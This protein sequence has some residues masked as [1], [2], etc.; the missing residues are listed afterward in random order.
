[1]FSTAK[2]HYFLHSLP[3]SN[4][5]CEKGEKTWGFLQESSGEK[6]KR[7]T[8]FFNLSDVL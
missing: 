5:P 1:M 6:E 8:F 3:L 2:D 7:P 4:S